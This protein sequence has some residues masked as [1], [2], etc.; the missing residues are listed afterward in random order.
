METI[1]EKTFS[2]LF[3]RCAK[4]NGKYMQ[5]LH[6]VKKSYPKTKLSMVQMQ[7]LD[8]LR[9]ELMIEYP[10]FSKQSAYINDFSWYVANNIIGINECYT[11]FKNFIIEQYGKRCLKAYENNIKKDC[12]SLAMSEVK[13]RE[14][15]IKPNIENITNENVMLL[16]APMAYVFYGFTWDET[17]EGF[18]YWSSI[19]QKWLDYIISYIIENKF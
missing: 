7:K 2:K 17:K 14:H 9:R 15:I 4:D 3:V 18:E 5:L 1:K 11:L 19:N 8:E 6:Y 12:V 16:L 10:R 13:L